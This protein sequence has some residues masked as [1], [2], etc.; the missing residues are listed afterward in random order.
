MEKNPLSA[1]LNEH[2]QLTRWPGARKRADQDLLLTYLA[3][4]FE[5][6]RTYTER[7]VNDIL[8]QWHTFEDWALLRRELFERGHLNRE[9]NGTAYWRTPSVTLL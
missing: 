4:K 1:Y 3:D 7:E 2:G 6:G 9:A 8:R 5:V